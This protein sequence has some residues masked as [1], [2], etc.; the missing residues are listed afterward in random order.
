M[1]LAFGGLTV[2]DRTRT[3]KLLVGQVLSWVARIARFDLALHLDCGT[4]GRRR[5]SSTV[6]TDSLGSHM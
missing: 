4:H 6:Y 3:G 2:F 1:H 5:T